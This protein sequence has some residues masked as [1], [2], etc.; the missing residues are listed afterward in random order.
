MATEFKS[1]DADLESWIDDGVSFLQAEVKIYRNPAIFAKYQPI[2]DRIR[3]LEDQLKPKKEKR[4]RSLDEE[5]VGG[6]QAAAF[7]DESLGDSLKS[8]VEQAIDKAYAEAEKLWAEYSED[9]EV[10][11][12]RRLNEEEVTEE[13]EKLGDLPEPPGKISTTKAS[14]KMREKWAEEMAEWAEAMDTYNNE[15]HTICLSKAVISV[16][17]KGKVLKGVSVDGIRRLKKRPGGDQHFKELREAMNALTLEGVS[18]MAPHRDGA[19]A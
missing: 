5:S 13:R 14:Q 19:G 9:C 6:D 10:W 4:E 17:V 2:M 3:I 7:T 12:L 8:E 15:L 1:E 11:T 18:I 16:N